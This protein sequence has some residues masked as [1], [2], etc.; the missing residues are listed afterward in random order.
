MPYLQRRRCL[1]GHSAGE[2]AVALLVGREAPRDDVL[3]LAEEV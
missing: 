1:F 2:V 3:E